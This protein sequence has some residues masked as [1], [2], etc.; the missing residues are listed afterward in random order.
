MKINPD[1]FRKIMGNFASGVTVV[2]TLDRQ[3]QPY[4]VTVNSFTSVSLD[5]ILILVCLHNR[6]GGLNSFLESQIFAI[7][8]LSQKQTDISNYFATPGTDRSRHLTWRGAS[9]IPLI[10]GC[11]GHLECN[12]E[13]TYDGGDHTIMIGRVVLGRLNPKT[14]APLLFF[15][16]KYRKIA[17]SD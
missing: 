1:L 2:S 7:N 10:R 9:G 13:H 3:D 11:I 17:P 14:R 4:G 6:L 15:K 8:I 5:P 12:L 16:G